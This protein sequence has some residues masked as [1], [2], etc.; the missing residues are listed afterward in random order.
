M[1]VVIVLIQLITT[2]VKIECGVCYGGNGDQDCNG[3]CFGVAV[4]DSCGVCSG[5]IYGHDAD[6]D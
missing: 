2:L 1:T 6:G 4:D 5:G 3:D